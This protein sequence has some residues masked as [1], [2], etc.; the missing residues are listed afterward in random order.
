MAEEDDSSL[1]KD[2]SELKKELESVKGKKDVSTKELYDAIQKL[3]QT[4]SDMLEVFGAAADQTKLEENEYS[5]DAKKHEAINSKLDRVIAQNKAIAEG[6]VAVADLLKKKPAAGGR[7]EFSYK[8][9]EREQH[10]YKPKEKSEPLFKPRQEPTFARPQQEWQ[11]RPEP[12]A[13]ISQPIAMP[14]PTSFSIPQPT[15]E[16][17][18]FLHQPVA[19]PMPSPEAGMPDFGNSMPQM[20][21]MEPSP[22]PDLDFPEES[23][24]LKEEPKKKGLFGLFKK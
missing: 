23:Q 16:P 12:M 6:V 17:P 18:L 21:P 5:P 9:K 24:E 1:Y 14:Q 15:V 4:M 3:A 19:P 10:I 11:P 13:P 20:P 22:S 8:P 7:E 2:I